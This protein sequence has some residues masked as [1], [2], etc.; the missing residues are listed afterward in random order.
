MRSRLLIIAP[1]MLLVLGFAPLAS[2]QRSPEDIL[3][4]LNFRS[5]TITLGDDLAEVVLTN[6][7]RYLNNTDTQTFL[8]KVWGNPPGSGN[9]SLGMLLPIDK[10]PLSADG[11]AVIISYDPSG[12]VS[13]SDAGKIDYDQLMREMQAEARKAN[14]ERIK[15]GYKSYELL[16]WA[17]K[18]YYDAN[19]KKLFWA[20]RLRFGNSSEETLN[21]D[22][23]VLGRRGVLDL[24]IVAS[25]NGLSSI[26]QRVN[27][28]LS[29]AHFKSGNTYAEFNPKVD[30]AAAYG[31][32]GLIAGGV[33]AKTGFFKGLI[34]V[35]FASKK[36]LGLI[37]MGGFAALWGGLKSLFT[38]KSKPE[39]L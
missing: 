8:T 20:K 37:V 31:L 30:E 39:S 13:D 17:R 33:L 36:L 5:G 7:F 15:L 19:A 24:N 32:A 38:R 11:W 3:K 12:Y 4:T 35:L 14:D 25:M 28:I 23:R 16:G 27:T 9:D 6:N 29:M 34:A 21:Y 2:A 10:D 1:I 26:D 18:P 22:I